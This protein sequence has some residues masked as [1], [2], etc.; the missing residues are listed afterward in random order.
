M[1][2]LFRAQQVHR[3][4]FDANEVQLSTLLS[5]KTGG[6][7]EDCA[8][9]PQ[10][11]RYQTGVEDE[12]MLGLP[13]V[14]EHAR[15]A[16]AAGATRFCMGAAW[17]APKDRD[18]EAVAELVKAV[19]ATGLEACATLGMLNDG[20]AETLRDAIADGLRVVMT[21]RGDL[22]GRLT[23][24]N[25]LAPTI[26]ASYPT[27]VALLA[28]QARGGDV[29]Q[30]L[31]PAAR[32]RRRQR[33]TQCHH[34]Q[35]LLHRSSPSIWTTAARGVREDTQCFGAIESQLQVTREDRW[36]WCGF[37]GFGFGICIQTC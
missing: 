36:R 6:C 29:D 3:E 7:P 26:L 22:Y 21:L 18:V 25:A 34:R 30:R 4:H 31:A 27:A 35:D 9:C 14:V 8:Y 10:S 13:E 1:D 33:R 24:L 11:R 19:K 20:H 12:E 16:K 23:E 2:L 32:R 17:R 37:S 5:I 28:E 15:A